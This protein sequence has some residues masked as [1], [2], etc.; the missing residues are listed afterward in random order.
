MAT[1]AHSIPAPPAGPVPFEDVKAGLA[2]LLPEQDREEKKKELLSTLPSKTGA[3]TTGY[4]YKGFWLSELVVQGVA[5]LE[6]R[7]QP[8][9]DDVIVASLPKCG[10][11]WTISL[12]VATMVR[13]AYP[14]TAADHPLRRLNPHQCLP[15]L[16]GLFAGGE[17][18]MLD[19]LPSPR[20]INTHMPLAFIPRATP[21]GNG[22]RGCKVVYV[23]REPKDMVVSLWHYIQR[24]SPQT[25][26][27]QTFDS[28]CDGTTPWGPFWD[29]FLGYWGAS[30][31]CPDNVL[32]MWYEKMLRE[33]I[34]SVKRLARFVGQPFSAAE[35]EANI[36]RDI[37]ELCSLENLKSMDA[38][39]TGH[40]NPHFKFPR[41]ALF[42][43]GIA[44]DWKSHMTMEMACRIDDIMADKFR[45]TG[46]TFQ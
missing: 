7:F 35:V 29:H 18:G 41:E 3:Y 13:R 5:A 44:G 33:P 10:T 22:G 12:T 9:P 25:T 4:C 28:A 6:Q 26:F 27:R 24:I 1:D 45:N 37:V 17:E 21:L 20:L 34:E 30:I 16:E 40:V 46:L 2:T 23:C 42:R 19:A 38:N 32:F 11:T 15:F 8:R 31:T 36:V 14:P 43:K 39:K